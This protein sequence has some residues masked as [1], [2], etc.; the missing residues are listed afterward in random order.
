MATEEAQG[1]HAPVA[2]TGTIGAQHMLSQGIVSNTHRTMQR[3]HWRSA[4]LATRHTCCATNTHRTMQRDST[5]PRAV[6]ERAS[7]E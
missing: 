1:L 3:Y 2:T 6:V 4:H 5:Y 7:R